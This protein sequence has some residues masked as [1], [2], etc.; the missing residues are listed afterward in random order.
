MIAPAW[1]SHACDEAASTSL[2]AAIGTSPVVARLL[3][4][5]GLSDPEIAA[6]FLSPS[7]DHLHDPMRLADMGVAIDRLMAAIARKERIAIHG[8]YD[9]DG[10]TST[11]IL[12]RALEML[13][14][15]VVH[16]IPERLTDGYGL[17][18]AALDRLH[19]DGVSL[20]VSV[21]C[22]IRGAD[23]ARRARELGVDLIITDH[24]EPDAEL[25]PA[26]A[27]I[28]PKR[29][30]CAY[31]D[32]H[33]AG[34]GVALKVVQAL[35]RR[36]GPRQLAAGLR[37]GRRDRHAGRRRAARRRESR[38]REDRPRS[39]D[40][41]ARTRSACARCSTCRASPARPSTATTSRSCSRRA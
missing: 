14:A 21:D 22:G 13:G 12:R 6:R 15:D 41:R 34:V 38:H 7:L 25:P 11:V 28:N 40:A 18:P 5:R 31:P 26:L 9:V 39:P 3:C 33:L 35:C 23:A 17:Q 8:D 29:H 32:K 20:V 27:V 1:D 16:F 24:H 10:V 4:Q 36:A 37:E 19:A 30:D 2:A